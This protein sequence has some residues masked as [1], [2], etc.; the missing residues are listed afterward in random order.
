MGFAPTNIPRPLW[1]TPDA[2]VA[3]SLRAAERGGP[4][5]VIPGVRYK[6]LIALV[7]LLPLRL[8]SFVIRR[9]PRTR[10]G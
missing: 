5:T 7:R 2:V 8:F 6:I 10:A 3:A 1:L 9:A 4:V